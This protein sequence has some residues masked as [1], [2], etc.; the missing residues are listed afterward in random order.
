MRRRCPIDALARAAAACPD[1]PRFRLCAAMA[2]ASEG[3]ACPSKFTSSGF[4][5]HGAVGVLQLVEVGHRCRGLADRGNRLLRAERPARQNRC[6]RPARFSARRPAA[7]GPGRPCGQSPSSNTE[8]TITLPARG[9]CSAPGGRPNPG[10]V[11]PGRCFA[12]AAARAPGA[13]VGQAR[14]C[15]L[16]SAHAA[17]AGCPGRARSGARRTSGV[18]HGLGALA[19]LS[20]SISLSA[21]T[22]RGQGQ[23]PMLAMLWSSMAMTAMRSLGGRS[24]WRWPRRRSGAPDH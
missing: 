21:C 1:G 17:P 13:Q 4:L 24:L 23:R 11:R 18:R 2:S 3:T 9:A 10:A 7:A 16:R 22:S 14:A 12:P 8:G 6:H 19:A 15:R 20:W 5:A